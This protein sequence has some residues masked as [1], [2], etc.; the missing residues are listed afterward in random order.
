MPV[1]PAKT[2]QYDLSHA[3]KHRN[4]SMTKI[5]VEKNNNQSD[6]STKERRKISLKSVD[7]FASAGK[8][9]SSELKVDIESVKKS[10]LQKMSNKSSGKQ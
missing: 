7:R 8:K 2:E 6:L 5:K 4:L 9:T 10:V 1:L 3:L